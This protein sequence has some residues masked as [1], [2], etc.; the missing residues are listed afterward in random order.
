MKTRIFSIIAAISMTAMI[1]IGVSC[2]GGDTPKP[3]DNS[4]VLLKLSDLSD[5]TTDA[6]ALKV[7]TYYYMSIANTD[8]Y[9]NKRFIIGHIPVTAGKHY[10]VYSF[11]AYTGMSI[12]PLP[13]EEVGDG[14]GTTTTLFDPTYL[15]DASNCN[16][17]TGL[18]PDGDEALCQATVDYLTAKAGNGA[19]MQNPV[20]AGVTKLY[21]YG[22]FSSTIYEEGKVA[23]MIEETNDFTDVDNVQADRNYFSTSGDIAG[24]AETE[25][26]DFKGFVPVDGDFYIAYP[27]FGFGSDI[28]DATSDNA[29]VV[30]FTNDTENKEWVGA[31]TIGS[32]SEEVE[33]TLTIQKGTA[34]ETITFDVKTLVTP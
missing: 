8:D 14:W 19:K 27:L 32:A 11:D 13:G 1:L 34:T 7:G 25:D 22:G 29:D 30:S 21:V 3:V 24:E 18:K 10:T 16:L 6:K 26:E 20:A 2:D 31:V 17:P 28:I 15:N 12:S 4:K 33:V 9:K 5:T 23:F